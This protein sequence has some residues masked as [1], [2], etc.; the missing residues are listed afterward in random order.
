MSHSLQLYYT[1]IGNGGVLSSNTP[2]L[3]IDFQLDPRYQEPFAAPAWQA[4]M[5]KG[6]LDVVRSGQMS[7]A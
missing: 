5:N 4:D 1:C 2:E 6:L 7:H 3:S